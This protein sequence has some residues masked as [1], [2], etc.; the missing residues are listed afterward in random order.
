[1]ERGISPGVTVF[2]AVPSGGW[3]CLAYARMRILINSVTLKQTR[4]LSI[5]SLYGRTGRKQKTT[6]K[7]QFF[8]TCV[9]PRRSAAQE[10]LPKL[11]SGLLV[12]HLEIFRCSDQAFRSCLIS[13]PGAGYFLSGCKTGFCEQAGKP[14]V[15]VPQK[16]PVVLRRQRIP[17]FQCLLMSFVLGAQLFQHGILWNVLP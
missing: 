7:Q 14:A 16:I 13:K 5:R 10:F 17:P 15:K 9:I 3:S 8:G 6:A 2:F 11:H 4:R 1:M 12:D